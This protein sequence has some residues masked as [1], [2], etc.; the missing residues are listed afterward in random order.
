MHFLVFAGYSFALLLDVKGEKSKSV[1]SL[2]RKP[3]S[4]N[5]FDTALNSAGHPWR[6]QVQCLTNVLIMYLSHLS[7][8][9]LKL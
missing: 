1:S 8:N 9:Y 4:I 5:K 6:S 7:S 3:F 2:V